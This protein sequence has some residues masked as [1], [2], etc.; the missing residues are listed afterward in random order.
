MNR[1]S[2]SKEIKIVSIVFLS[3]VSVLQGCSTN[4]GNQEMNSGIDRN[5][6]TRV[7]IET[8]ETNVEVGQNLQ[9]NDNINSIEAVG[10]KKKNKKCCSTTFKLVGG[11][12]GLI[13][14]ILAITATLVT[15][16]SASN[17]SKNTLASE[18]NNLSSQVTGLQTEN[19][20]LSDQQ[21]Y[22]TGVV[23]SSLSPNQTSIVLGE[24]NDLFSYSDA[25]VTLDNGGN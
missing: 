21:A 16:L 8:Q 18:N 13:A 22:L 1:N 24:M 25:Q 5:R 9:L 6:Q 12:I 23:D 10:A 20:D 17:K 4:L 15:L 2:L 3:F 11:I 14:A 19:T 7:V